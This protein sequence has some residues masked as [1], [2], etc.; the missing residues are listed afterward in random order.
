MGADDPRLASNNKLD[1]RLSRMIGGWKREDPPP[2]RVKPIPVQV[3]RRIMFVSLQSDDEL[4]QA[5]ADMTALGFFY[6]LR[7]GEYTCDKVGDACPFKIK[8]VQLFV[9]QVR[10]KLDTAMD[11]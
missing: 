2:M 5:T 6:L 8:D 3:I 11:E 10:I 9:G 7:P 1:F 4:V